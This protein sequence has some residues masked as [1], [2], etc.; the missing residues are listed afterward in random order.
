[1]GVRL[2]GRLL[3]GRAGG[4]RA[5]KRALPQQRLPLLS[6]SSRVAQPFAH[7]WK[8]T[9]VTRAGEGDCR[10]QF[11]REAPAMALSRRFLEV[12]QT[13][14]MVSCRAQVTMGA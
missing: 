4:A 2:A 5:H 9:L 6:D 12:A 3:E 10:I 7:W 14:E 13:P 11:L 8:T 1:M